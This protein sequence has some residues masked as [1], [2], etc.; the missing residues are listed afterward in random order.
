[1]KVSVIV[2]YISKV[3]IHAVW[4]ILLIVL[5]INPIHDGPFWGCSSMEESK[6]WTSIEQ[7]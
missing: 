3:K 5:V 2:L 6:R 7:Y 4:Y 1:M